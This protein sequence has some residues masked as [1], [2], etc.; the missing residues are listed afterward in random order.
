MKIGRSRLFPSAGSEDA[1]P[2]TPTRVTAERG[3]D[4]WTVD[5]TR[6]DGRAAWSTPP[7][8]RARTTRRRDRRAATDDAE[9]DGEA[10]DEAEDE[11]D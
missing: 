4:G 1:A 5:G 9:D 7:R 6:G 10:E 11:D 3:L 2:R 8:G